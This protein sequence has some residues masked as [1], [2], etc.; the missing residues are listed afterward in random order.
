VGGTLNVLKTAAELAP[1]A[2]IVLF[3][4]AAEYGSVPGEA[5]PVSES[6]REAP[7]SFFGASKLA[8]TR[9][10]LAAAA[11]WGL[12][13]IVARPFNLIGPGLPDHYLAA[14]LARRLRDEGDREEPFA[15][16]NGCASRDF[17]D[18]RDVAEAVVLFAE[19]EVARPGKGCVFNLASGQETTVLE[20]AEHLCRLAGRRRAVDLGAEPSRSGVSRSCG[21]ARRARAVGWVPRIGWKQSLEDLWREWSAAPAE[22]FSPRV[23]QP[24]P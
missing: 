6:Q 2:T 9:L 3:G 22:P 7:T 21:D 18:V 12:R 13:I 15:V 8:Q 19:R 20:V 14:A 5:L 23:K 4:S 16:A 11:E 10:G 24:L 17:V 1:E